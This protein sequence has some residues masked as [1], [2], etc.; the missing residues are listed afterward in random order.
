MP[1]F[2]N[3][4]EAQ[5][6]LID[7]ADYDVT[8]SVDKAQRFVA[9]ARAMLTFSSLAMRDGT[10]LQFDM[11]R[12]ENQMNQAL[13]FLEIYG[14]PTEAN[15]LRNPAVTHADFSTFGNYGS[16]FPPEANP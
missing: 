5:A 7:T 13:R 8:Y 15:R 4:A 10:S 9:A 14:S 3:F 16:T 2:T 11:V 1:A 12:L 6:E